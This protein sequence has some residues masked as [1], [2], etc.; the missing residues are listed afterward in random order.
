M[1]KGVEG[2][3]YQSDQAGHVGGSKDQCKGEPGAQQAGKHRQAPVDQEGKDEEITRDDETDE[4][5]GCLQRTGVI[6]I[7]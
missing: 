3:E 6:K 7:G 4:D 2:V 1:L 5:Q